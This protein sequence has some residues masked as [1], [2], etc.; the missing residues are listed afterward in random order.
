MSFQARPKLSATARAHTDG[1][2]VHNLVDVAGRLFDDTNNDGLYQPG[3]GDTGIGGVTV[4]LLN[5][6][7][8]AILATQMTSADGTY[9]F[10]VNLGAGA[11]EIVADQL[12][13]FL[14]GNETAGNLGGDV[15]NT[16]D[17]NLISS[18][19]VGDPGTTADA[20]DYLF[21]RLRPSRALGLVWTDSDNDGEVDFGETAIPGVTVQLSGQDDRGN[22]VVRSATT[23]DNGI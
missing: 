13:G 5:Q 14:D 11:Y 8:G 2:G 17:A 23:D 15:D 6:T 19:S 21:A 10:D 12:A 18:I 3:D 4:R 22:A 9:A 7:S 20:V 1:W 16:Q